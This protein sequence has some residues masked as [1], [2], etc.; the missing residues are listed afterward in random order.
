[1][2]VKKWP[3]EGTVMVPQGKH[4]TKVEEFEFSKNIERDSPN[5]EALREENI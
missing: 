5:L 2:Y 1:M 4:N 3:E